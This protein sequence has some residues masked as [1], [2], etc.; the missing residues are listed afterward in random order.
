ME[1]DWILRL[2]LFA[3]MHWILAVMMLQD[4]ASRKRVMGGRKWPW[5]LII[6][7]VTFLGSVIY[8]ICHPRIIIGG[9]YKD[10][11]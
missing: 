9:S 6:L 4:L 7:L 3:V 1:L 5:A 11:I 10:D 8:L 2:I